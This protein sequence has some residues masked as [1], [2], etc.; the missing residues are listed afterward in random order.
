[1]IDLLAQLK[2]VARSGDGWTA[3]CPAHDDRHNSLSIH[4]RDGRW[5]LRCH[6]GCGWQAIID[7][8]GVE[9]ADLF[10]DGKRGGGRV[11]PSDN[12]ATAQRS[13]EGSQ[14]SVFANSG[15]SLAAA[16]GAFTAVS[17]N[18]SNAVIDLHS[19]MRAGTD[20]DFG[21]AECHLKFLRG[22]NRH[23]AYGHHGRQRNWKHCNKDKKIRSSCIHRC[24]TSRL[25]LSCRPLAPSARW[26]TTSKESS[27]LCAPQSAP[28]TDQLWD[29]EA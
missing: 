9:A 29:R 16:R 28:A 8:L 22:I 18:K 3:R 23:D 13:C 12:R 27:P 6:A 25:W 14:I 17:A 4:H 7:A 21:G 5:L 2:G 26:W 19:V 11:I 20:R 24:C 1:M 10:D 15:L